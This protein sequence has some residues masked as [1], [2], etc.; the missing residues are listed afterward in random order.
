MHRPATTAINSLKLTNL[1]HHSHARSSEPAQE[2]TVYRI[3]QFRGVYWKRLEPFSQH[4]AVLLAI[5]F[6]W[7]KDTELSNIKSQS[8]KAV[9]FQ[10]CFNP[11][12]NIKEKVPI[13]LQHLLI[14]LFSRDQAW[15]SEPL[16]GSSLQLEKESLLDLPVEF[17]CAL[18][19]YLQ[20]VTLV[21]HLWL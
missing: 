18:T 17:I 1:L 12:E 9:P 15:G 19:F 13:I 7:Y 20:E 3:N 6:R 16:T 10:V 2:T 8:E 11:S 21:F 5:I 14:S 4:E